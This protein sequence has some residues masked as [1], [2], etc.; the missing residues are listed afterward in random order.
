VFEKEAM[1]PEPGV[2]FA[3]P[4]N[5]ETERRAAAETALEAIAPLA[6]LPL[7]F[8]LTGR[9]AAVAGGSEAAAWKAE[10]L[11]AAGA[12]VTVFAADPSG[13][14]LDLEARQG[15][16]RVERR[17]WRPDDLANAAIAVG[18]FA[19]PAESA[20]FRAAGRAAGAPVNVVDQPEFC[21][22]SFGAIVNRSPLV[23]GV[24]TG[25]AAPVFGQALRGRLEA[26]IP[27]GFAAWAAAAM[28]WRE[29]MQALG[30]SFRSR[31]A[32]WERFAALALAQADRAPSEEDRLALLAASSEDAPPAAGEAIIV[33]GAS[34]GAELLTLKAWRALQSAEAIVFDGGVSP[35]CLD[36]ARREA[37]RIRAGG[38]AEAVAAVV[39][40]CRDGKVV[41]RLKSGDVGPADDESAALRATGLSCLIVPGVPTAAASA[42]EPQS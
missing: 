28:K 32:F 14:M 23:I 2:D 42:S 17:G 13:K 24:S 6:N 4:P 20:A 10:L 30:A 11:A 15:G 16:V 18:D 37:R 25:G 34:R 12:A 5:V 39:A 38:G 8:K 27:Q 3:S 19:D 1:L 41:V 22:F 33:G 7:F 9:K 36:L 21:D 40:L 31:R 29:H 35:D 26:L